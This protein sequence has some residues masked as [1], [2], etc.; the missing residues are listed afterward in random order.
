MRNGT[1]TKIFTVGLPVLADGSLIPIPGENGG[2]TFVK[3]ENGQF[4]KSRLDEDRLRKIAEST[5][6]FYV[7]LQNGPA[8]MQQIIRQGLG[9]MKEKEIDTRMSRRPIERY[10]WPL[11]VA[12][13]LLAA[14]T[15]IGERKRGSR[16]AAAPALA[17]VVVALLLLSVAVQAK[18]SGLEA[19]DR[20]DYQGAMSEFDRQ[21]QQRQDSAA[22]NFDR[23]AAAYKSGAYDKALEGFSK[24]VTSP[25]PAF[26]GCG[27]VQSRQH[28]VS[29]RR[30][31][32]SPDKRTAGFC[33]W[34]DALQHYEQALKVNPQNK[35]AE[36]NRD[37][38]RKLL[39]D[40][41]EGAAKTGPATATAAA[42]QKGR[43]RRTTS[44]SSSNNSSSNR[45]AGRRTRD[46]QQQQQSQS[47]QQQQQQ[48]SQSQSQNQQSQSS[49]RA[50][51][52]AGPAA[53][54]VAAGQ[55]PEREGRCSR[56][57]SRKQLRSAARATRSGMPNQIQSCKASNRIRR[58][59][60]TDRARIRQTA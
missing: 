60:T 4:V 1:A 9:Q 52:T 6:G 5:G 39:E 45:Q 10:Q 20:E 2:T 40:A 43:S 28:P 55:G 15:L 42:E 21:L 58:R 13:V 31:E 19:Y 11:S 29:A 8:E 32:A 33:E 48:Q 12:L 41:H 51:A 56:S 14:S 49:V 36:Y 50:A 44:K 53:G 27:G 23:G 57:R 47:Q 46:Q 35:D 37:V 54:E 16:R 7:H 22:L 59:R 34:K 18:N 26:A 3:D 25:D 24:A 30:G 38:V 17:R